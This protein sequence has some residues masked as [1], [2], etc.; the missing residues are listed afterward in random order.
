M[1]VLLIHCKKYNVKIIRIA[2]RPHNIKPEKILERIQD[3]N[4]C[5]CALITIEKNDDGEKTTKELSQEI[6]KMSKE[7]G[8]KNIVL[9]PFAHLS[10]NLADSKECIE[11]IDLL[12]ERLRQDVIVLRSHFGSDKELLLNICG[13]PGNVRYREF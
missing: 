9:L 2:T 6:I 13:H 1:R 8:I 10:N 3:C 5:I 7:V 4:N 11:I 12:Q